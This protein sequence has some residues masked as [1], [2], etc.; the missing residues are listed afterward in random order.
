[1]FNN[2]LMKVCLAAV[3]AIGLAACSS[4]DNGTDTSMPTDPPPTATEQ[5][6]DAL[7][8]EIAALRAQLGITD[9]D[10]I[11][12][13]ID[14]LMEARDRLQQQ[15]DD[16]ADEADLAAKKAAAADAEALFTGLDD[17]AD[18]GSLTAVLA[19]ISV[20]DSDDGGGS[21]TISP[22]NDGTP[23]LTGT[24]GV[25]PVEAVE[26]TDTAVAM[27]GAWQGTELFGDTNGEMPSS[28]AVV[29]TDVGPNVGKAWASVYNNV[30]A[31][32]IAT[33]RG[34]NANAVISA[35]EFST[36]GLKDHH[37]DR[38]TPSNVVSVGGTFDGA[39]GV[40]TCTSAAA[41]TC[42][43][44]LTTG[45]VVLG[46]TGT[47]SF[48][49]ADNAMV[50]QPDAAYAYFGWWL[51]QDANGPEV[52]VFHGV[53]GLAAADGTSFP[54]LG[55]TATYRGS[56][57]GKYAID[58]VA[59]GTYASG[60]HWTA[61]ATLTAN[62]EDPDVADPVA[63][64]GSISGTIDNFMS[65][66]EAMDWSV[67]LGDTPLLGTATFDSATASPDPAGDDVVWTI[68]D[69]AA[70]EA[71]S[72]SGALYDQTAPPDGNNVPSTATG[73]FSATYSEGGHTIGHMTGAFGAHVE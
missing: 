8:E 32:T 3:F 51:H 33:L 30:D 39:S 40:Y 15:I 65:D 4:S 60:G 42:T 56:A 2:H 43:S 68:S 50:S 46:G 54:A 63:A 22:A 71:G 45:G 5:E 21:A 13:S 10:D 25:A 19:E 34:I 59:P 64:N 55:G 18:D 6:L 57:A 23:F 20:S 16:A 7:K 44:N 24:G 27:L 73:E 35:S 70:P 29:Y 52:D 38:A 31:Q 48:N 12:D 1:M 17:T 28:T 49:P 36:A 67:S 72:W 53:T 61:D 69:E 41:G 47:W 37:G 11:G 58:P 62:F 14:A 9:A 66:G 26:A